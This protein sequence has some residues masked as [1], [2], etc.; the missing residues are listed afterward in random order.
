[1]EPKVEALDTQGDPAVMT[2]TAATNSATVPGDG[3]KDVVMSE[4]GQ[5]NMDVQTPV[6]DKQQNLDTQTS[7]KDN[8]QNVATA[9]QLSDK[10]Q[11]VGAAAD[12]QQSLDAETPHAIASQSKTLEEKAE[13]SEDPEPIQA[14]TSLHPT[15]EE[16]AENKSLLETPPK[17]LIKPFVSQFKPMQPTVIPG[18]DLMNPNFKSPPPPPPPPF[19]QGGMNAAFSPSSQSIPP[20]QG[21]TGVGLPPPPLPP[22]ARFTPPPGQHQHPPPPFPAN[23]PPPSLQSLRLS[24]P[25]L[26][27]GPHM[28]QNMPNFAG[29]NQTTSSPQLFPPQVA[30]F[31]IAPPLMGLGTAPAPQKQIESS[32]NTND[33]KPKH[34]TTKGQEENLTRNAETDG[35]DSV[36]TP[37]DMEMSSPEGDIIDKLNEE[38]W[39]SQQKERQEITNVDKN[40]AD[41]DADA[42]EDSLLDDRQLGVPYP[43]SPASPASPPSQAFPVSPPYSPGGEEVNLDIPE[44]LEMKQERREKKDKSKKKKRKAKLSAKSLV[45]A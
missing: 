16:E 33:G 7:L 41:V 11:D 2:T 1:M 31:K 10:S 26:W 32:E 44:V 34:Q 8:Q 19:S 43:H 17:S 30:N 6:V 28:Q 12:E 25:P 18:L 27:G 15:S 42:E 24:G 35:M 20:V 38:F 3:N 36:A 13:T 21:V 45:S 37:V 39:E 14:P 23:V 40:T 4:E 22:W 5:Q 29:Q 9:T